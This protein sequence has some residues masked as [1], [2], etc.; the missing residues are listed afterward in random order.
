[1]APLGT[2]GFRRSA[3]F[4]C[5]A[6]SPKFS[7]ISKRR[8]IQHTK[9]NDKLMGLDDYYFGNFNNLLSDKPEL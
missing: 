5:A 3:I 8:L 2:W 6:T 1:M 4:N 9:S 7:S